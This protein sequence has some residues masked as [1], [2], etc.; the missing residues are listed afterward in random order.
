MKVVKLSALGT[1]RLYHQK[2]FLV[3][4][5]IRCWVDPKVNDT[6]G[7]R[8]GD[9]EYPVAYTKRWWSSS[10]DLYK[11]LTILHTHKSYRILQKY[12]SV[13]FIVRYFVNSLTYI[14]I[15][16]AQKWLMFM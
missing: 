13:C 7:N 10:F 6:I 4:I 2:I 8:T 11:V 3:L 15:V 9:L 5:S 14:K 12:K 16:S 1:G